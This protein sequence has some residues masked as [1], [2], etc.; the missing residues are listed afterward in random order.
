MM[1]E[2][3]SL[4][5]SNGMKK[6]AWEGEARILIANHRSS[7]DFLSGGMRVCAL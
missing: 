7:D 3:K 5:K 1:K 6:G 2:K 4:Q